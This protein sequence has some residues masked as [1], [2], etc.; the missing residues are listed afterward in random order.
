M[1]VSSIALFEIRLKKPRVI[2]RSNN[3]HYIND[4]RGWSEQQMAQIIKIKIIYHD[5][6]KTRIITSISLFG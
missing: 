6:N 2:T 1:E 3:L 4:S 5:M